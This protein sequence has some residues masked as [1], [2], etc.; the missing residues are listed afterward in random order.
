MALVAA[1]TLPFC[2]SRFGEAR[3]ENSVIAGWLRWAS[4]R[5]QKR[6][7]R[8]AAKSSMSDSDNERRERANKPKQPR[9]GKELKGEPI[10][11]IRG[12]KRFCTSAGQ[13]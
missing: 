13:T 12:M 3:R 9:D 4:R 2:G 7:K 11:W 6:S 5:K 8:E 1:S 10:E